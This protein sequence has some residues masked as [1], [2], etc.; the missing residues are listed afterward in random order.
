MNVLNFTLET[1]VRQGVLMEHMFLEV[2]AA[3]LVTLDGPERPVTSDATMHVFHVP[4]LIQTYA[5]TAEEIRLATSVSFVCPIGS[6]LEIALWSALTAHTSL[7]TQ[8]LAHVMLDGQEPTVIHLA[9]K[10]AI[11]VSRTIQ[12]HVQNALETNSYPSVTHVFLITSEIIV[13]LYV[14]KVKEFTSMVIPVFV[15]AWPDGLDL[16]VSGDSVGLTDV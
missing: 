1:F 9:M 2:Q 12:K 13:R 3:A 14:M 8:G 5:Q 6:H 16:T 11:L 15:L 7:V 10:I 4:K